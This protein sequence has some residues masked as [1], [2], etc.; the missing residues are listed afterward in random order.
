MSDSPN[1][2]VW[3]VCQ[4]HADHQGVGTG[5]ILDNQK[6]GHKPVFILQKKYTFF[7]YL[8]H[9]FVLIFSTFPFFQFDLFSTRC[10]ES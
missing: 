9:T 4:K 3:K 7:K 6:T 2:K 5:F 10:E 8:F 1:S